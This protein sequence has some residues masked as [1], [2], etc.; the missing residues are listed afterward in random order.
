MLQENVT[1]YYFTDMYVQ[2]CKMVAIQSQLLFYKMHKPSMF[3]NIS[4]YYGSKIYEQY[5]IILNKSLFQIHENNE[6]INN[7]LQ[8]N[9]TYSLKKIWNSM[10]KIEI[11]TRYQT[12]LQNLEGKGTFKRLCR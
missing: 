12:N 8:K 6:S 2:F 11:K 4:I 7:N 1:I 3:E 5:V 9:I 10:K